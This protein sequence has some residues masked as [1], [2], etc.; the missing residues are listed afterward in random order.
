[1]E[2]LIC[3]VEVLTNAF[4]TKDWESFVVMMWSSCM[5]FIM[6]ASTIR[7]LQLILIMASKTFRLKWTLNNGRMNLNALLIVFE[8]LR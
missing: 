4:L 7:F 6:K 1:V 2:I 5:D 3:V 8:K